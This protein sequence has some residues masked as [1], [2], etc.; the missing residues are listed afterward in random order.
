M[1]QERYISTKSGVNGFSFAN[2][3]LFTG[4]GDGIISAVYSLIL[5]D[6]WKSPELVGIY[7]SAYFAFGLIVQI[8][9]GEMLRLFSKAKLFY[10]GL[11]SIAGCYVL[12]S[13]SVKPATFLALDFFTEVPLILIMTL[14]PLF[15]ADFAGR[16]GLARMNGRYHFWLNVG[17]LF[18]P[19]IAMQIADMFGNRTAFFASAVVYFAGLLMF[20]RY[21]IVQEDKKMPK[22]SPKRTIKSVR[23]GM[24]AYFGN[25]EFRRAYA[26]NFGYY[27]MKSLRL[28]YWPIL[29]IQDGF[30][31]DALG[32]ALTLGVVPYVLLS[33]PAG[34]IARRFGSR[35]TRIGLATAFLLFAGC[36]FVLFFAE[37]YWMMALFMLTQVSG[38]VQES[39]H[40]MVFF[41]AAKRSEQDRFYGVFNTST[42]LPKFIM[43]L[44]GAAFIFLFDET[45]AIWLATGIF[46]ILTTIALLL[47][48]KAIKYKKQ[49]TQGGTN[50]E[51]SGK[52]TRIDPV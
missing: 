44:I 21:K 46:G 48:G 32:L 40:D 15:M 35:G 39:L 29:V 19:M 34:A 47:K 9:F 28:L 6:I 20:R 42:N 52:H 30:S 27:A 31:K 50:G 17:C 7:S 1:K 2:L 18:A 26:V 16:D 13:F 12:L 24:A 37:G 4:F 51:K 10:F 38:A 3:G 11:A 23:R 36:S 5:L 8:F 25:P 45:R 14:I 41:D 49:Q 22:L 33:E 43:P